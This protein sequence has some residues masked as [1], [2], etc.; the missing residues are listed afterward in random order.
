MTGITR[1]D[2]ADTPRNDIFYRA[3]GISNE[4]ARYCNALDDRLFVIVFKGTVGGAD[5]NLDLG[6]KER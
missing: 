4:R 2:A 3:L 1:K 5:K 6:I